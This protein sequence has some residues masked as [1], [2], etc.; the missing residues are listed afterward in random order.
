[1]LRP[2]SANDIDDIKIAAISVVV[3]EAIVA[4]TIGLML[5][6]I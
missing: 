4:A 3:A 1:V 5:A 6:L 2:K